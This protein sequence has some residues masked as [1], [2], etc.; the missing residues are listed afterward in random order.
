VF[1]GALQCRSFG[2]PFTTESKQF[3]F[4]CC[5]ELA[6]VV[7][8]GRPENDQLCSHGAGTLPRVVHGAPRCCART[9]ILIL[10][11][12][13]VPRG[14]AQNADF[15]VIAV[16]DTQYYSESYPQILN[17][18]MQWIVN[19]A[20]ALNIQMVLGLGDIVNASGTVSEWGNADAA[21][22][23]LD[24]AHIPYFA[25]IG[26]HD[27]DADNP[28]SRT[29]ATKN[30]NNYFGPGRYSSSGYWKGS[31]PSGSNENFYGV[32]TINGQPYLVLALEFYPRD[33]SL[34]WAAQVI[35]NN[36]DKQ[37]IIITH[38]YEY[39]DNTRVSACNSFDAQYYGLGADND[40]DAMW[41]KLVRQYKNVTL[42]LS[43]HEVRSAGQDAAGHRMDVG[44]NGNL[45][46]QILSNYQNMTN[47]G[48]GYLRIMKFHPSTDTIDVLT[49]S[50]YLNSYLADSTNQFTVPWHTWT[51][52]GNGSIVGVVKDI[53]SCA[54][55]PATITSSA[56]STVANSSGTY[57]L[58]NLVPNTYNIMAS[59]SGYMPVSRSIQVGPAL[60]G[61]GKLFLGTGSGQVMGRI[62]SSSGSP[63]SGATVQLTG[64]SSAS[65]QDE[66]IAAD[67]NGN[68]SSGAVPGGTYQMNASA[69]GY[70]SSSA[71]VSLTAGATV[72]QNFTLPASSSPPVSVTSVTPNSGPTTGGTVVN[73][74]GANFV[75]GATV[76]VGSAAAAVSS[77]TST[78]ITATMPAG[79]AG[80][81]SVTVT[82]PNGGGTATLTGGFN[83]SSSSP[84]TTTGTITGQ[85][86][87]DDTAVA[88]AGAIV[89]YSGG[90]TS[91]NSSGIFTLSNIPAG[92]VTVTA[93][94]GGYQ[95]MNKPVT[96]TAGATGTLN[97]ALLPNCT[98]NTADPSVTICLPSANS[99]VL[100]PVHIIAKATDSHPVN[101][102][103]VWVDYIKVYQLSGAS[104]N[105][106]VSMSTGVTHRVTVQATDNINQV[107]KQTLYVT[108]H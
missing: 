68:Y 21:Y 45:V 36:S 65:A 22:K 3:Y 32:L 74:A 76:T 19:N 51:G 12:L 108:V 1:L 89:A 61:S 30:F 64:S 18:Q 100:N 50:P 25:A 92:N 86:T 31:Y 59:Y 14:H 26:N 20:S 63:L 41:S 90:G 28:G 83:Y 57:T 7:V 39:F 79:T 85:V 91:T 106:N 27:Y 71:T 11:L 34:A 66:T 84:S 15:T 99:T 103:Q 8:V 42:V 2:F 81:A 107:I 72:T 56:G 77:V 35:Q 52:T 54:A 10:G 9:L 88:L 62:T 70:T 4:E 60:A 16:P 46:N 73:I 80:A 98:I 101:N 38:S 37:I 87:K 97:F 55:L 102:L 5:P 82:N 67:T 48:N 33:R 40:G 75:A 17:S 23:L 78:S 13:L 6:P 43:G 69:T 58:S 49:Y 44:V 104:L 47:G 105:A 93:S 94:I 29:S 95:I 53:S 24:A 96:V